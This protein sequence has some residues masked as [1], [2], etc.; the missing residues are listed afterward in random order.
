MIQSK[1]RLWYWWLLRCLNIIYFRRRVVAGT[2]ILGVLWAFLATMTLSPVYCSQAILRVGHDNVPF[3]ITNSAQAHSTATD[4][5]D[6]S[7]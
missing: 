1:L 5:N 2:T 3:L 6:I 4:V 7:Y